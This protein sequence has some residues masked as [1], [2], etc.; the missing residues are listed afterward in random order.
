MSAKTGRFLVQ[1]RS[2]NVTEPGT[3]GTFGGAI[4]TG[5]NPRRTATDE[6]FEETGYEDP[7]RLEKLCL[8]QTPDA[9][10]S[11]QNFLAIVEDEFE[12]WQNHETNSARWFDFGDWPEPLHFGLS[13]LLTDEG[14]LET[15]RATMV[16]AK[17]GRDFFSGYPREERTLYHCLYKPPEGDALRASCLRH[18]NGRENRFLFATPYLSKALAFAFSYHNNSDICM[19]G[20]IY[21]TPEE[22]AVICNRSVTMSANRPARVYAFS[23]RGFEPLEPGSRQYVTTTPVPFAETRTA[24]ETGDVHDIMRNGLQIFSVAGTPEEYGSPGGLDERYG[25]YHLEEMLFRLVADGHAI[26]ENQARMIGVSQALANRFSKIE[27]P[28]QGAPQLSPR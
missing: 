25:S 8:Y 23:S 21:G 18:E 15:I 19:N 7:L 4:E 28:R 22:F 14:S 6:L 24:F 9:S 27:A 17:Q 1:Q 13:H 11:Y 20:P 16:A 10:F 5:L 3:W 12:P 2:G 26:W